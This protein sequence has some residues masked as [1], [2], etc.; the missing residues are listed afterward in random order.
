MKKGSD[1]LK[2]IYFDLDGTIADLYGV[3]KWLPKLEA[4]NAEPYVSAAPIG[5]M[6]EL[7]KLLNACKAKG[8]SV[9]VISWLAKDSDRS[10]ESK[11][12]YAKTKWLKLNIDFQFDEVHL[13]KYGTPK[14]RYCYDTDDILFDDDTKNRTLWGGRAYEPKDIVAVLTELVA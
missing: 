7:S 4:H 1:T 5:D 2:K 10:F 8:Y 13:I 9:G 11:V 3:D 12:R 14:A 6:E